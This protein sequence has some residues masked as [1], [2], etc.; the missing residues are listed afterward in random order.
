MAVNATDPTWDMITQKISDGTCILVTG[1]NIGLTEK[2]S[3][4]NSLLKEYLNGLY[5][6][7][8]KHYEDDGFFSVDDPGDKETAI[9]LIQK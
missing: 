1:P 4:I 3:S 7:A 2:D 8:I 9:F 6:D 5:P